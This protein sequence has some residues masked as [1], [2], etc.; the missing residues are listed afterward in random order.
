M[1]LKSYCIILLLFK[2]LE[3][4]SV[5]YLIKGICSMEVKN[6]GKRYFVESVDPLNIKTSYLFTLDLITKYKTI[7]NKP[8]LHSLYEMTQ[9]FRFRDGEL[10]G[11]SE[12]LSDEIEPKRFLFGIGVILNSTCA[13]LRISLNIPT[14]LILSLA[15]AST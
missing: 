6:N 2:L 3:L 11:I 10:Q 9:L 12:E 14:T 13:C 4:H 7:N 5:C 1:I 8:T 15:E